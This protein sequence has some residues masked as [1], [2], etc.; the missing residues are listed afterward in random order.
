MPADTGNATPGDLHSTRVLSCDLATTHSLLPL[1][2]T[3]TTSQLID[4]SCP[5]PLLSPVI[6]DPTSNTLQ[7]P[8]NAL[9]IPPILF[10]L[11]RILFPAIP[12]A[13]TAKAYDGS[14]YNWAPEHQPKASVYKKYTVHELAEF[15]GVKSERILLAIARIKGGEVVVR[16]VF[17]VT[18][19]R[20]FYG[21]GE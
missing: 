7:N 18:A 13:H 21:P 14:S 15:D 8:L 3:F 10:L 6:M 9:L 17:D 4:I 2:N 1:L 5:H 12:T 19:G 20:N 11:W 16:T